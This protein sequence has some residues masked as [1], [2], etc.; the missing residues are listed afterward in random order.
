MVTPRDVEL[1]NANSSKP[2]K[3]VDNSV[4]QTTSL[5]SKNDTSEVEEILHM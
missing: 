4:Y 2:L 5:A 1:S 3:V